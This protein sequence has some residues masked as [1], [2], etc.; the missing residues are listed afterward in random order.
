MTGSV[1]PDIISPIRQIAVFPSSPLRL[2]AV[3]SMSLK[4]D[5]SKYGESTGGEF[6]TRPKTT[7]MLENGLHIF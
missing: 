2:F 3:S 5:W 6:Y 7:G 1:G 4:T